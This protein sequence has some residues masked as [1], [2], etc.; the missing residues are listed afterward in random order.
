MSKLGAG[1][2]DAKCK[3]QWCEGAG[4][5]FRHVR[6]Q[7][8]SLAPRSLSGGDANVHLLGLVVRQ[9]IQHPPSTAMAWRCRPCMWA[10]LLAWTY[11]F[12]LLAA[13]SVDLHRLSLRCHGTPIPLPVRT[14]RLFLAEALPIRI[15]KYRPSWPKFSLNELFEGLP[16]RIR[17]P[18]IN[19]FAAVV[20]G[21]AAVLVATPIESIK[22]GIQTWPGS[23]LPSVLQRIVKTRGALGFFT[24]IHMLHRISFCRTLYAVLQCS[25]SHESARRHPLP[26]CLTIV[27]YARVQQCKTGAI[28]RCGAFQIVFDLVSL[29]GWMRCCSP[30]C[31]TR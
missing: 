14:R 12:H 15:E 29:Q 19:S 31:P 20:A 18:A 3:Q 5:C 17:K 10:W 28:L 7:P 26:P 6:N 11:H 23:T 22:V 1:R 13:L 27:A 9:I 2:T 30:M 25:Q 4:H 16:D 8:S 24:G 21:S